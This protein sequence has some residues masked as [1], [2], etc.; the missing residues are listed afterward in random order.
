MIEPLL[1]VAGADVRGPLKTTLTG[2]VLESIFVG[3]GFVLMVPI[4]RALF[5]ENLSGAVSWLALMAM[6]LLLYAIVRYRTQLAAYN[7]AIGLG[8]ALFARL[9]TK[10]A[11]LP[12]G[13]FGVERVGRIGRLT[14]QSVIDVMGVPAHLLRPLV[15]AIATPATVALCMFAFDWRLALAMFAAALPMAFVYRWSG[16]LVERMDH[17]ADAAAVDAVDRVVE[18]AQ[19][20]P[21]LRAF[22]RGETGHRA[23]DD[24]LEAQHAAGRALMFTAARGLVSFVVTVQLAFTALL[25]LGVSLALGGQ[26]DAAELVALLV[27]AVRYVEPLFG[28]AELEG[29]M[30]ISRNGLGRMDALLSTATLPEP[31]SPRQPDGCDVTFEDVAFGYETTPLLSGISFTVPERSMT[32]IVGPSGSGKTTLLRLIARFWDVNGGSISLG[33]VDVRKMT[34]ETLMSHISVVCQDVYL[35]EGTIEENIRLGR[36][37]A[38]DDELR[39][40]ARVAGVEEIV[41]RLPSGLGAQVG[42][43]GARLSG[44]ER[45]RISIARALLKNAPIVLLDEATAALDPI[46]EAAIQSGLLALT[47]QKTLIVVA[48]RLPTV[49]AA[50]QIVLLDDGGIAESGTHEELTARQG[51]YAA[52]WRGRKRAA[53][54]RMPGRDAARFSGT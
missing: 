29:A 46:N 48:H 6:V 53:G 21:V 38:S 52:F 15:T 35:F 22:G 32:A 37:E 17:G 13:W 3:L 18:F 30:R 43:G 9:G 5:E 42:E 10:I 47:D 31:A 49:R 12:I 51:R 33:G 50:D 11:E 4:L 1:R 24:A 34:T 27:L 16:S 8:R 20:Q 45:Q 28:A 40:A 25:V 54:W 44:G 39:E 14:S 23:L 19:A 26:V 36:P 7:A 2:L 41:E